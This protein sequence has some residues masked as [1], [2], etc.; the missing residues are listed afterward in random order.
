MANSRTTFVVRDMEPGDG[1][2]ITEALQEREGVQLVDTD[3]EG[4]E[5]SVR[6][7]EELISEVEIKSIVREA[8]YE[9]EEAEDT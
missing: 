3:R 2:E 5:V 4:G 1:E 8:G 7:G 9:V 6:F